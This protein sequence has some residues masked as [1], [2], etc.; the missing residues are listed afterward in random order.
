MEEREGEQYKIGMSENS[1]VEDAT[2]GKVYESKT[3][4]PHNTNSHSYAS[5]T[6]AQQ[7]PRRVLSLQASISLFKLCLSLLQDRTDSCVL[8]SHPHY[9]VKAETTS[10]SESLAY[11][12]PLS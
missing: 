11:L 3:T 2:P 7:Q 12:G 1:R 5:G 10:D 4:N 6:T 9:P 8:A